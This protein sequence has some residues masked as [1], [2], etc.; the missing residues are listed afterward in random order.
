MA[1]I[2][3]LGKKQ[4]HSVEIHEHKKSV[5]RCILD[6]K[7]ECNFASCLQNLGRG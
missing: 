3:N 1:W 6:L 7:I 2:I 5:I 4:A